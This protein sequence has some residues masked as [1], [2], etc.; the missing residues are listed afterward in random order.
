MNSFDN[1]DADYFLQ[2]VGKGN[3]ILVKSAS[4]DL[5]NY[6][7]NDAE[8]PFST[9]IPIKATKSSYSKKKDN[10]GKDSTA[11]LAPFKSFVD[12]TISV[13]ITHLDE[14]LLKGTKDTVSLPAHHSKIKQ[15]NLNIEHENGSTSSSL[16]KFSFN[17]KDLS[18]LEALNNNE[19]KSSLES[20]VPSCQSH[21]ES[22]SITLQSLLQEN[23]E[24]LILY[25]M[26]NIC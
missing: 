23:G 13:P 7:G 3:S 10:S 18:N 8:I 2:D 5:L 25:L 9:E 16:I 12:G 17:E 14:N 4:E 11:N 20:L 15:S 1:N 26:I 24:T 22:S 6:D 19:A 21:S